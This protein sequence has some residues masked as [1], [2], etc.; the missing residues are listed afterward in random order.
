MRTTEDN[1]N[2]T[3]S[4]L[5][6]SREELA[7]PEVLDVISDF[8]ETDFYKKYV[9]KIYINP[10][11]LSARMIFFLPKTGYKTIKYTN[12]ELYKA[13]EEIG[14]DQFLLEHIGYA[15]RELMLYQV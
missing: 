6:L 13:E 15:P 5:P 14:R 10:D 2:N 3:I 11:I 8:K 9:D 12:N 1:I 7:V 4:L